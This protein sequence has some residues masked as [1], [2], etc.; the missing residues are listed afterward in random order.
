MDTVDIIV[1]IFS[2]IFATGAIT[3]GGVAVVEVV[4]M[5]WFE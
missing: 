5:R 1:K 3:L 2:V 4:R